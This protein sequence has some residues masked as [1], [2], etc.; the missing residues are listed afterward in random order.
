[1]DGDLQSALAIAGSDLKLQLLTV[2]SARVLGVLGHLLQLWRD[3]GKMTAEEIDA[4]IKAVLTDIA[5][6]E[7]AEDTALHSAR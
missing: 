6:D 7:A 1:M 2:A 5:E 3:A 4:K